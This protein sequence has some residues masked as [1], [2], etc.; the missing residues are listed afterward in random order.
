MKTVGRP[1]LF[2][3]D[4]VSLK[5]E[6]RKPRAGLVA[7]RN[8]YSAVASSIPVQWSGS[9]GRL[10]TGPKDALPC[11]HLTALQSGLNRYFPSEWPKPFRKCAS[12]KGCWTS[13]Q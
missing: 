3:D 4:G 7:N 8:G 13:I 1:S 6:L 12:S 2:R 11:F 5:V 9:E 10:P